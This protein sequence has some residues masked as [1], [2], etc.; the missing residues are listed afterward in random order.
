MS[1]YY[2]SKAL[3]ANNKARARKRRNAWLAEQAAC[4]VALL[5]TIAL[6]GAMVLG[7][8]AIA[9]PSYG[10]CASEDSANCYWNAK[11]QG[12]GIG[13]S[14]VDVGGVAHYIGD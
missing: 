1:L 12:N 6:V 8:H 14:F 7:A 10:P 2:T 13:R 4:G 9:A 11:A 3:K 5:A